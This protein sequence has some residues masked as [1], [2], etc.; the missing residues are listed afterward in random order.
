MNIKMDYNHNIQI[1]YNNILE[2]VIYKFE[3]ANSVN[4]LTNIVVNDSLL[5]WTW[6]NNNDEFSFNGFKIFI[7]GEFYAKQY[8][9]QLVLP[10][11][12]DIENKKTT[13]KI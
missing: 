9:P 1:K 7:N 3:K 8:A 11:I 6:I 13:Y 10:L 5:K 4:D 2:N 12:V